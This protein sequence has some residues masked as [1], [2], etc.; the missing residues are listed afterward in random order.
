MCK[1]NEYQR[2]LDIDYDYMTNASKII[3]N[4]YIKYCKI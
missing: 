2:Y 1:S 3:K 4:F